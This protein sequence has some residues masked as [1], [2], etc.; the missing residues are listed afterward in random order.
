MKPL[1]PA[2]RDIEIELLELFELGIRLVEVPRSLNRRQVYG[3]LVAHGH[4]VL[5]D[6]LNLVVLT[7]KGRRAAAISRGLR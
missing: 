6:N 4:V 5:V 2:D 7:S 1:D 3:A